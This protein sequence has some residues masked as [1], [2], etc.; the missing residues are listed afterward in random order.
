MCLVRWSPSGK[1]LAAGGFDAQVRRWSTEGDALTPLPSLTGHNGWV[2][3]L[4]FHPDDRRLFSADSWGRLCCWAFAEK[5]PKPLWQL[6]Q[7]HDGWIRRLAVSPDGKTVAS[8]GR[9]GAV[10]LWSADKGEKQA[11]WLD[12]KDDVFTLA[13]HPAGK[14]LVSGDLHG[15]IRQWDLATGKSQ[16]TLDAESH[17]PL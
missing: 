11:E 7:A 8:C 14:V 10:R 6:P 16:R 15:T 4:A 17:V 5:E 12:H 9:D 2:Q 1:V 13:F 3:A